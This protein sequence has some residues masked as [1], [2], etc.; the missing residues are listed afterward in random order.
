M[1]F[2]QT[3]GI[4]T[5]EIQLKNLFYFCLFNLLTTRYTFKEY[6]TE[7]LYMTE[8]QFHNKTFSEKINKCKVGRSRNLKKNKVL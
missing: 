8:S 2:I 1:S 7:S 6:M 5:F 3:Y 4:K